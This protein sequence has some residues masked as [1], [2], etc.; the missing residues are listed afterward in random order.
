MCDY[1]VEML[2]KSVLSLSMTS[3]VSAALLRMDSQSL[4]NKSP[5]NTAPPTLPRVSSL[6]EGE[7]CFNASADPRLIP[8]LMEDC[9]EGALQ[10]RQVGSITRNLVFSRHS[11]GIFPLPQAFRSGTCVISVD[12]VHDADKDIF[13]LWV[14]NNAA[15]DLMMECVGGSFHVGGK[16]FVGPNQVVYVMVFGRHWPPASAGGGTIQL[17]PNVTNS[18]ALE[19]A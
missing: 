12:V 15:L 1:L 6:K 18:V 17:V 3:L 9:L 5:P 4:S 13:P 7:D 11:R 19:H 16:K 2:P 14:V 8:A 10:I